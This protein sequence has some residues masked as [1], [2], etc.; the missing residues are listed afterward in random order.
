MEMKKV[1]ILVAG[2]FLAFTGLSAR[3]AEYPDKPI[4]LVLPFA[5]GGS[6]DFTARL[7]AEKM[8]PLLGQPV[9]VQ[10]K[11][12]AGGSI[13]ASYVGTSKPDGY[14]LLITASGAFVILPLAASDIPYKTS[15][16]VPIG[17][18]AICPYLLVV[19][20]D[21]PAKSLRDLIAYVK[22]N[23]AS[24]S[25]GASGVGS[26]NQLLA[27][28][29]K[30]DAHISAQFIPYGGEPPTLTALLGN[31]IHY[32]ILTL[33]TCLPHV[34]SGVIRALA[35]TSAKREPLYPQVP[36]FAEQG[37]PEMV[38]Y[39][40]FIL[41]APS[42]TPA[43]VV[44]KLENVLEKI[45]QDEGVKQRIEATLQRVDFK[46]SADTQAFLE[47]EAKKWVSVIKAA[48]IVIK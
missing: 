36:T 34:K 20:K 40:I 13:G 1:V 12:G 5:P 7:L 41:L 42:K 44:R 15:D 31:N 11:P 14:T 30:Q 35:I 33:P 27:E 21:M 45:L 24:V 29:L 16:F 32:A 17:R 39:N 8:S 9:W 18:V 22:K 4:Q 2:L 37:F 47:S 28:L 43:P 3:G 25:Y 23:P 46:N 19:N 38:G 6:G 48:G 10:N 26:N